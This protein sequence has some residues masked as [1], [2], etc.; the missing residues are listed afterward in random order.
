M[1]DALTSLSITWML[2]LFLRASGE[3]S[4]ANRHF[5]ETGP[6][7]IRQKVGGP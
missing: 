1:V 5:V 7:C 2:T 6:D 4:E 3:S